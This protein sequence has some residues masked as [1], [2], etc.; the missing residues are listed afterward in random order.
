MFTGDEGIKAFNSWSLNPVEAKDP[1]IVFDKFKSHIEPNVNF[2]LQRFNLQQ[3]RQDKIESV[4]SY[5][6]RCMLQAFKCKFGYNELKERLIEQLIIE[7]LNND[8]T[9]TLDQAIN[10]ARIQDASRTNMKLLHD[11]QH[12]QINSGT[13]SPASYSGSPKLFLYSIIYAQ[14]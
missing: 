10:T 8:E 9:L 6:T 7:L 5:M 12:P 2:R 13:G 4:D 11:V 14:V 1:K 3:F